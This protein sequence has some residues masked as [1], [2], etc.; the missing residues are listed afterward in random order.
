VPGR[1]HLATFLA[2]GLAAAWGLALALP[3]WRGDISVLDRLEG[4]LTDLRF[5]VQGER[6]APELITIIAIDNETVRQAGGY[7]L[8][9]A[10]LAR[11][12]ERIAAF[13]P[14][15]IALDLLLVD[16]VQVK[17]IRR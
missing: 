16:R 1:H 3:H 2:A 7:P 17:P 11:V 4:A 12:V 6:P 14:R 9:R 5:L 8:N 10:T 15:V 13:R